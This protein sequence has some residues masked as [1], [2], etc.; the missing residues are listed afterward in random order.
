MRVD[1]TIR[2]A[3][4]AQAVAAAA[5]ARGVGAA[6]VPGRVARVFPVASVLTVA[7]FDAV[8]I[9]G[10]FLPTLANTPSRWVAVAVALAGIALFAARGLYDLA[11]V[12]P[13]PS[14]FGRISSSVCFILVGA[15]AIADLL[16]VVLDDSTVVASV[17]VA[18]PVLTL[19]H[20]GIG[21]AY[22]A[23]AERTRPPLRVIVIGAGRAGQDA[24]REFERRGYVVVGLVDR[25]NDT[26]YDPD[27]TLLGPIEKLEEI[28]D[29][30][31]ID[32]I[33]VSTNEGSDDVRGAITRGFSRPI[34]VK[35]APET[36][37]LRLPDRV[38]VRR[39]GQRQ[40]IDFAPAVTVGWTKRAMDLCLAPLLLVLLSPLFAVL[41]A[42]ITIESSG[43][44][45]YHQVRVG[46]DRRL[47]RIY[48]FRSMRRDA[49]ARI[50]EL[51][52]AN[53]VAGPMFKIRND[54]RVTRVGRVIRRLSLDE[55]PQLINVV[56]GEMSLVG[57]RPP[58]V[59]EVAQYEDWQIG[60]LRAV[61]GMTG[62]WQVSGRTD[63]AFQEMVRLDL[64]YVRNWS[65]GLDLHILVRTVPAILAS[66]GAY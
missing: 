58:L 48:K 8:L 14:Q 33:V 29:G 41:A 34:R 39:I 17:I 46:K 56:K 1:A 3:Q 47:F 7:A 35:Y 64:Q 23:L 37:G 52:A 49:E 42:A 54:P 36:G 63:L 4:T 59:T 30:L 55:L 12:S 2:D 16:G 24:A 57:P 51:I 13:W 61:P 27:R 62:L 9:A 11:R 10:P 60:R 15:I 21:R 45:F 28:V 25:G 66:R 19:W 26:V 43:P 44:V 31:A 5:S 6:T 38:D 65:L 32:E 20:A 40:Y 22:A 18:I 50:G 53:E